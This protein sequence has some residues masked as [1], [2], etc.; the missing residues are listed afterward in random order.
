MKTLDEATRAVFSAFDHIESEDDALKAA[1]YLHEKYGFTYEIDRNADMQQIALATVRVIINH[2][3]ALDE[4]CMHFR[5]LIYLGVAIGIE[6]EKAE[7]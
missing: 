7:Q 3:I 5:H 6:M 2:P 4:L 1:R